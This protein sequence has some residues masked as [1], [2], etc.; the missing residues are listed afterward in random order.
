VGR[1]NSQKNFSLF[2]NIAA[3]LALEFPEAR[4][5]LAG[6]G[7]EESMLRE[8]ANALGISDRVVFAGYVAD[9]RRVYVAADVLLMPS[10][11]EGLPMTLL[12]A[13]AMGLPVVA[14]K[15]DGIAEVIADGEEGFLVESGDAASFAARISRLLGNPAL[16]SE[17]STNARHK[18]ESRFSVERMTSAVEE[19]YERFLP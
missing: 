6:E 9:T 18:I 1:L 15:L 10:R 14:S 2:L 12:E 4:F 7:P 3:A 5:L 8:K 19:I 11:F 17:L 13:M 16:A